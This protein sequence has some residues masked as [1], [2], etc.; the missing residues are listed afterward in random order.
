MRER[1]NGEAGR[2][3][4]ARDDDDDDDDDD[5]GPA[6]D[7]FGG[8]C[9]DGLIAID[10]LLLGG[11]TAEEGDAVHVASAARHVGGGAKLLSTA[12]AADVRVALAPREPARAEPRAAVG[13]LA[14][15][16]GEAVLA[17]RP[18]RAEALAKVGAGDARAARVGRAR[19]VVVAHHLRVLPLAALAVGQLSQ[20]IVVRGFITSVAAPATATAAGA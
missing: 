12:T 4:D 19:A 5:D 18:A 13:R 20:P 2:A 8:N 16:A 3:V 7:V 14:L 10:R 9:H 17:V 6:V 1:R 11:V 15:A